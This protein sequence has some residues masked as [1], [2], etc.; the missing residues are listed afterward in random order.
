[1][2]LVRMLATTK[3]TVSHTFG[4]DEVPTDAAGAVTATVKRLDGTD[5]GSGTA[6]HGAAGSGLYSRD[7]TGALIDTFTA[8]W[9]G[10][11]GGSNVSVRD[12]V[13]LTGGF[14]FELPD[15][16]E[17]F[18]LSTTAWPPAKLAR[19]RLEVEVECERICRRAFV[20][21]FK[22]YL[23]DGSGD[24]DLVVPDMY[25]RAVRAASVSSSG[26]AGP[27]VALTAGQLAALAALDS[28]VIVRTD[29]V[30]P[31]GRQNVIVEYEHGM[32]YPPEDIRS[33][34]RLRLRSILPR[35]SSGIPDRTISFTDPSTGGI[36]RLSLPTAERTGIPDV[37][38]AYDA[39]REP[40]VWIA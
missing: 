22:R 10:S 15:V 13:E 9:S 2:A 32:D 28:G 36:Y 29:D 4:A 35:A 40:K 6:T 16:R 37:D 1:V 18:K 30:W 26:P 14:L 31:A 24:S 38:G 8:D 7:V 11:V 17:E 39:Y 25:L 5:A 12:F 21:R 27:F 33:A 34:A 20:P 23:L 19:K 3:V